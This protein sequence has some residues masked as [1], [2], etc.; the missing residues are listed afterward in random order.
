MDDYTPDITAKFTLFR[1][2]L[3][4]LSRKATEELGANHQITFE[5][6]LLYARVID[7]VYDIENLVALTTEE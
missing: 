3:E 6:D 5:L 7:M 4:D 1:D 2:K